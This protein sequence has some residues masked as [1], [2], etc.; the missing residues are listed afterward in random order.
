M[1]TRI[2]VEHPVTELVTGF[3]LVRAQIEIAA[4]APLPIAQA[5]VELRGHAFECRINAEDAGAGFRP[6]PGR[7]VRYAE[8]AGPG[9]RVDSGI[10]EGDEVVGLYDPLIAKLCVWD[11]DRERA[12]LRMLRALDELVVEGV[13]TLVPLHRLILQHPAFIAGETCAGL[14]EGELA[15]R[16]RAG[17]ARRARAPGGRTAALR[18]RGRRRAVRGCGLAAGRRAARRA[19]PPPGE[20]RAR[21]AWEAARASGSRVRCRARCCGSR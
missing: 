17:R 14:I 5:D 20:R 1:N 13:P 11:S 9:V 10:E 19:A 3:D 16:A 21:G 7:V 2:Q 18:G 4:G 8:P 12:R 15:A 6:A